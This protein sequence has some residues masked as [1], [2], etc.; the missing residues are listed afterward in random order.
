MEAHLTYFKAMEAKKGREASEAELADLR[1][2]LIADGVT[3]VS[4]SVD[5][6]GWETIRWPRILSQAP[7]A[8]SVT[9]G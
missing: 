9:L 5:V 8:C 1:A 4:H 2:M 7:S 6:M 3:P